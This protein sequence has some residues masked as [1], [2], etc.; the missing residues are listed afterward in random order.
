MGALLVN[1]SGLALVSVQGLTGELAEKL[2]GFASQGNR[3]VSVDPQKGSKNPGALY[4]LGYATMMAFPGLR[5]VALSL[6]ARGIGM[7]LASIFAGHT[8]N[9][10]GPLGG[11]PRNGGVRGQ[12]RGRGARDGREAGDQG[13]GSRGA[14]GVPRGDRA[15]AIHTTKPTGTKHYRKELV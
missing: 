3:I 11:L 14:T 5:K 10:R 4:Y 13:G 15:G 2:E 1:P 6:P 9:R 7:D 8:D 12:C